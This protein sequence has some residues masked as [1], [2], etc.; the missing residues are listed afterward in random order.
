MAPPASAR[1]PPTNAPAVLTADSMVSAATVS[2]WIRAGWP[3]QRVYLWCGRAGRSGHELWLGC[4]VVVRGR[5]GRG[6]VVGSGHVVVVLVVGVTGAGGHA[7]VEDGQQGEDERLD[8]ADGHVEELPDD[9][10]DDGQDTAHR[11]RP[12]R[13]GGQGADQR[14]QDA[15]G[16]DVAEESQGQGDR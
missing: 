16:E 6:G 3:A 14:Q 7:E 15:A 11:S 12:E 13:P 10:E 8:G 5:V 1:P 4:A 2:P 9:G